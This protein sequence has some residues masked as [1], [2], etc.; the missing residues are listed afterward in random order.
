MTTKFDKLSEDLT[1]PGLKSVDGF[2]VMISGLGQETSEDDLVD[3]F[4]EYGPIKNC[5]MNL[6][7]RTGYIKGY[8]LIEYDTHAEAIKAIQHMHGKVW[9]G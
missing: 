3:T 8:A 9:N 1:G 6:D 4:E 7:R 2:C 5:V